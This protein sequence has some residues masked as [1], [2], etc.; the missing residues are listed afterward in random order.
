MDA[1]SVARLIALGRVGLGAGFV[2][3]PGLVA[4]LWVGEGGTGARVLGAGFG[5]RDVAIG[6]GLWHALERDQDTHTW[7]LAGAA[8]DVADGLATLA[9]RKSLPLVGRLGVAAFAATGAGLSLWAARQLA[10]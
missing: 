9:A 10:P 7:L 4:R 3:A 2:A 6:A 8:G 1:T 5:A